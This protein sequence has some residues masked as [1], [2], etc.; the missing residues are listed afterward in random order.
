MLSTVVDDVPDDEEIPGQVELLDQIELTRY[1]TTCRIVIRTIPLTRSDLGDLSQ[2]RSHRF[3]RRHWEL[4]KAISEIRHRVAQSIGEF[5]RRFDHRW[6]IVKQSGHHLRRLQI[7][8]GI[9][10]ETPTSAGK[11]GLVADAGQHIV[12]GSFRRLRKPH[13]VS[14]HHRHVTS[15][16]HRKQCLVVMLLV[17]QEMSLH[18]DIHLGLTEQPEQTI[19]D[20]AHAISMPHQRRSTRQR[21]Q[22]GRLSVELLECKR[23]FALGS[24]PFHP[25]DEPAQIS[26]ARLGLDEYRQPPQ[27]R[28]TRLRI[29]PLTGPVGSDREL[30][31]DD[32]L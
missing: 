15:R 11:C 14:R 1:L 26:I 4:W 27:H 22:P 17:T 12:E 25:S 32:R 31:A 20:S 23:P 16:C 24:V 3:P 21:D 19:E 29:C 10:V 9:P 18:L 30:A 7:S 28:D 6:K 2:K 13:T 5:V 8:F